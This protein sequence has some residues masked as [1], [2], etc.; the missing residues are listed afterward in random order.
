MYNSSS[1]SS[2]F[3]SLNNSSSNNY[4]S[5]INYADYNSI[6]NGSYRKLVKAY[7]AKESGT[8]SSNS[9]SKTDSTTDKTTSSQKVNAATVRDSA[10]NLVNDVKEL[11]SDKL[12]KKTTTTDK[13]GVTSTDYDKDAIYKAVSSFA[14]DY[15]SLVS[16][17]GNSS[18]NS[19]LRTSSTM[20]AYTKANKNLLSKVGITVGSDNKLT[21]DEDKFK[22]ADM[23]T[24][25]SLFTGSGSFGKMTSTSATSSYSSAVSQ[26]AKLSSSSTYSNMGSYSYISGSI[27]D[28]FK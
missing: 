13:D 16:A 4:M 20:V 7:Y 8:S 21:V 9:T 22:S 24:V 19:V 2:L 1:I 5:G 11:S 6:R 26:L 3:S 28:T 10:S 12:W 17:S 14:K 18:D 27:Y 15:N 23:T 25:K